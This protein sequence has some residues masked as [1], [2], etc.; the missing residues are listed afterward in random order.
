MVPCLTDNILHGVK[1]I[2]EIMME[3][4]AAKMSV[5]PKNKNVLY[6]IS[7]ME[8]VEIISRLKIIHT[9]GDPG[10]ARIRVDPEGQPG[11]DYD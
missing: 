8:D 1:V 9:Q 4:I 6:V 5:I 11:Q 3:M 7:T 2:D 10:S